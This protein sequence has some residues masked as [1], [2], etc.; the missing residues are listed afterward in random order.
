MTYFDIGRRIK[1]SDGG[2]TKYGTV[3]SSTFTTVTG[4][5]LRLDQG[6]SVLTGSLSAISIAIIGNTQNSLPDVVYRSDAVNING[7]LDVWLRGSPYKL[8]SGAS[9]IVTADMWRANGSLS[10]GCAI[11]VSR[12][13]RSANA[14]NVPTLAQCGQ[15]LNSSLGISISAVMSTVASG[16]FCYVDTR[17]EGYNFRQIAQKPSTV[18]F[19]VNST[20]TGTYCVAAR[21]SNGTMA[22]VAAYSIS[23]ASTWELKTINIPESPSTGTWDYSSGIGLQIAFVLAAGSSYQAVAGN[24]TATNVLA[25]SA[26][27]NFLASTANVLKIAGVKLNEG[28]VA[29]PLEFKE[30]NKE[31]LA[32]YRYTPFVQQSG[33]TQPIGNGQA[34]STQ[35]GN[36]YIPFPCPSRIAPSALQTVQ[37][38]NFG[39]TIGTGAISPCSAVAFGSASLNGASLNVAATGTPMS[40]G[41]GT[42]MYMQGSANS[43]LIF[44]G[45]EL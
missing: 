14:S 39:I 5:S 41:N 36:I 38:N 4:I 43:S 6:T 22:F 3:I 34:N 1:A 21:N 37:P 2:I 23:A 20:L 45:A 8:S 26:Q 12:F 13:E 16:Q 29:I 18:S 35:A 42:I 28:P 44:T 19:W 30:Y 10:A 7:C 32:C 33:A 27:V 9:T 40:A 24:W 25:T 17:I 31:V 15:L 11:R